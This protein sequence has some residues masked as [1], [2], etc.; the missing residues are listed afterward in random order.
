MGSFVFI[1]LF[2]SIL[3]FPASLPFTWPSLPSGTRLAW[4]LTANAAALALSLGAAVVP[5]TLAQRR[6]KNMEF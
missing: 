1:V 6:L 5:L 4:T 2:V 3:A